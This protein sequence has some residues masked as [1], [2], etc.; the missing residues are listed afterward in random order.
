MVPFTTTKRFLLGSA[1]LLHLIRIT[2]VA[3]KKLYDVTGGITA[4]AQ[5]RQKNVNRRYSLSGLNL[6]LSRKESG[7]KGHIIERRR[8]RENRISHAQKSSLFN[9]IES[10][11]TL[12]VLQFQFCGVINRKSSTSLTKY[13]MPSLFCKFRKLIG[14]LLRAF[15]SAVEL[16]NQVCRVLSYLLYPVDGGQKILRVAG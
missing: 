12:C 13:P 10:E 8:S 14:S 6:I 16:I 7:G 11:M 15:Y 9:L 2:G 5:W 1:F 3:S 4:V